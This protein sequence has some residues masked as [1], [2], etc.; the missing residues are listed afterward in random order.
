MEIMIYLDEVLQTQNQNSMKIKKELLLSNPDKTVKDLFHDLFKVD[1][2]VGKWYKD[3]NV[4][5]VFLVTRVENNFTYC[6]GFSYLG[7]WSE[8]RG[9]LTK[10]YNSINVLATQQ[11]VESALIAE[12]KKRGFKEWVY[13]DSDWGGVCQ[14][15]RNNYE[16]DENG[17]LW[18]GDCRVF[19]DGV[20]AEIIPTMTKK[21]AEEKL[22][23]K[24]V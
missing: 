19:V 7:E 11:E 4:G 9:F 2:E 10:S 17:C 20:W 15:N 8:E 21:Q 1:L 18:L 6:I 24:I 16:Y 14:L 3:T 12:A 23:V 13:I 5:N 22:N